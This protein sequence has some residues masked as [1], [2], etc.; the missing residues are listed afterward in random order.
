[1]SLEKLK[2][3]SMYYSDK[4]I[5]I[6][7]DCLD[8]LK[9]F[10]DR[11]IDLIFT[12][13]PYGINISRGKNTIGNGNMAKCRDYGVADWDIERI[14]K[15]YFSE[16]S[17]ISKEQA[18]FGA[19]YYTDYTEYIKPTASWVIWDKRCSN[20]LRNNF[21][22]GELC[23]IS[24]K[25]PT[26]IYRYIWSGFIREDKTDRIHPTEKPIAV[27]NYILS[28]FNLEKNSIIL[29]P[30]GGSGNLLKAAIEKGFRII[31]IEKQEKYCLLMKEW[32]K[33]YEQQ[34]KLF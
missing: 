2:D 31:Y 3:I 20:E 6:N 10:E 16:I 21:G 33:K 19:N 34:E 17:R 7:R 30:F 18:I 26:R 4:A 27:A 1:M 15:E 32:L 24:K 9:M 12:D 25:I 29:D 22:D 13:P 14:N 28:L 23:Y 11:E 8:V 5:V